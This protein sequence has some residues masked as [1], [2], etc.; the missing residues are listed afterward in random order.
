MGSIGI[1]AESKDRRPIARLLLFTLY[2]VLAFAG[3]IFAARLAGHAQPP[4]DAL[5][6]LHLTDCAL[7]CWIGIVPGQ[8]RF[9][10]AMRRVYAVYPQASD[11]MIT[12]QDKSPRFNVD[13]DFGQI[14]LLADRAGVVHRITLPIFRLR[15]IVLADVAGLLG[16]PTGAVGRE[17][18]AF[19]YGCVNFQALIAGGS[20]DGGWRQ[21]PILIDIQDV[22]Y[23]C[24]GTD[25]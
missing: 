9:D 25:H 19:Y 3:L 14:L 23:S 1:A 12:R 20:V 22:G 16:S 17:P 18:V 21:R 2:A 24:P 4:P 5:T 7:P 8:T 10:E 15:G 6:Q 11:A 13:T